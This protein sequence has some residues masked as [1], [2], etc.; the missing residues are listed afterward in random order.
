MS[1]GLKNLDALSTAIEY[2][3]SSF[4]PKPVQKESL[5]KK[6]EEIAFMMEAKKKREELFELK[7]N[8]IANM[9]HEIRTPMNAIIGFNT[10]L[11]ATDLS[12]KQK[13]YVD[14]I[15]N[16]T[17]TLL[18]KVDDILD[19]SK[20]EAKK[21]EL[22]LVSIDFMCEFHSVVELFRAKADEKKITLALNIDIGTHR[23][24]CMDIFRFRQI[25]SNLISNAIKFTKMGGNILVYATLL[26]EKENVLVLHVGVKDDG[27]GVSLEKQ[28]H[29]FEAFAQADG[30]TTRK[31]GGTGLGLSIS[32]SLVKLMGSTLS[33]RSKENEGSDFSF[34]VAFNICSEFD[35]FAPKNKEKHQFN[36][37]YNAQVLVAEDNELNSEFISE[38]LSLYHLQYEIVDNG[39]KAVEK[40]FEKSY[41]L[42]LMDINMP[43]MGGI[44]AL[45]KIRE[46]GIT[47]PIVALTAS[48]MEGDREKYLQYGFDDYIAKPININELEKVFD[49]YFKDQKVFLEEEEKEIKIEKKSICTIDLEQLKD[50]LS[51]SKGLLEKLLKI[52]LESYPKYM[53]NLQNFID[54]KD[55]KGIQE[56]AHTLKGSAA[57]MKIE[58]IRTLANEIEVSASKEEHFDYQA[59]IDEISH[60]LQCIHQEIQSELKKISV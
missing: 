45:K 34:D 27:I 11:K 6:L 33:V 23:C 24:L 9:S 53:K 56:W 35:L 26:E 14:I 8:F 49:F 44:D 3:I 55:F 18:A 28:K 41:D 16:S 31:F 36:K 42:I 13:K 5:L 52:F 50:E 58:C 1:T 10:L 59:K 21:L 19:F 40:V 2:G 47:T 57:S 22:D 38:L 17:D 54:K 39:K 46:R 37:N 20:I 7:S 25:I 4:L 60:Y 12:E 51:F 48:S 32:S 30:S 43:I 29:I 15:D